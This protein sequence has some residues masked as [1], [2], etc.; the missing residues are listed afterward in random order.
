MIGR[1]DAAQKELEHAYALYGRVLGSVNPLSGEVLHLLARV[2]L[3]QG[4]WPEAG[5]AMDRAL[6]LLPPVD[7]IDI[8]R[9]QAVYGATKPGPASDSCTA[10]LATHERAARVVRVET[11]E[12]EPEFL[13]FGEL[14]LADNRLY[15]GFHRDGI[16]SGYGVEMDAGRQNFWRGTYRNGSINGRAV[17]QRLTDGKTNSY[18]AGTWKDGRHHGYG[19]L[20]YE[21]GDRYAGDFRRGFPYGLG[22]FQWLATGS[23]YVGGFAREKFNGKGTLVVPGLLRYWGGWKDGERDGMGSETFFGGLLEYRGIYAAG[24]PSG[25]GRLIVNERE[26]FSGEFHPK[27]GTGF[28]LLRVGQTETFI[29]QLM[30]GVPH[31]FGV[32]K[33]GLA[34]TTGIW[35]DGQRE[36]G[37]NDQDFEGFEVRVHEE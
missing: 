30:D 18:Y 22:E 28:G 26:I 27:T 33:A 17:W 9:C 8:E 35:R 32:Q 2:Y 5:L 16:R 20:L 4:A 10:G 36:R 31:G 3:E 12:H 13:E 7:Q 29:G 23:Y 37:W 21:N 6:A 25:E 1:F 34:V 15:R 11:S 14:V 19:T 24:Q